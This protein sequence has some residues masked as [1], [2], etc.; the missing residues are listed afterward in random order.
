[1]YDRLRAVGTRVVEG[2]EKAYGVRPDAA[3][4]LDERIQRM[5]NLWVTRA[6]AVLGIEDNASLA[7]GDRIRAIVN[8]LDRM[9]IAEDASEF[10]KETMRR[11]H[12]ETQPLYKDLERAGRFLATGGHYV[13]DRPTDERF[14][15]VIGRMEE[16]LFGFSPP[17]GPRRAVLTVGEPVD[18]TLLYSAYQSDPRGT[19]TEFTRGLEDAVRGL[20]APS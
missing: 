11:R 10:T 8:A 12:A 17:R 5:K 3:D 16:E 6:A 14:M 18:V 1:V 9:S 20:L 2:Y 13:A 19:V 15:E 4:T 7:L